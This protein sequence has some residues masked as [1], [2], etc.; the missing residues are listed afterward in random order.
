MRSV[1]LVLIIIAS[2]YICAETTETVS[3]ENW[4]AKVDYRA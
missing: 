3:H 2:L 1:A 4:Y